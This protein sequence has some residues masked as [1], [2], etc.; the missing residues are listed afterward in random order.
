V[1]EEKEDVDVDYERPELGREDPKVMKVETFM[2]VG[3]VYPA[4]L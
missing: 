4:L 2:L 3:F 1:A